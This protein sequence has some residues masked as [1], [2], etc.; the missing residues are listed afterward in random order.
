MF[1]CVCVCVCVSANMC[2]SWFK[3]ENILFQFILHCGLTKDL[4]SKV[5]TAVDVHV[6]VL[7][8]MPPCRWI[9][10]FQKN[11]LPSSSGSKSVIKWCCY[12]EGTNI[13]PMDQPL[14]YSL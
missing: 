13:S 11:M 5:L 3:L 6:V 12:A 4:G 7:W 14:S 10:T 1:V 2:I 9:S 8:F